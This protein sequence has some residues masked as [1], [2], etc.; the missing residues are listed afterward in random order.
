MKLSFIGIG[1]AFSDDINN[2]AY[3]KKGENMLLIDCGETVFS[4]IKRNGLVE[5]VNNLFVFI[6]HT[7]SDHIGSLSSLIHYMH[8][9][10]NKKVH[11][12]Y[13]NNYKIKNDIETLLKINGN[14]NEQY[15]FVMAEDA[16]NYLGLQ[17]ITL[18]EVKHSPNLHSYAIRL[19][20]VNGNG[21]LENIYYTGD[22]CDTQFL[23]VIL[24]D[25]HLNKIYCDVSLYGGVHLAYDDAVEIF[26]GNKDKVCFMHLENGFIKNR[27]KATGFD[28]AKQ[29]VNYTY[30]K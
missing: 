23:K 27:L 30:E 26:K 10:K 9:V 5:D 25:K 11:L 6:T 21:E 7:H 20:K 15:D 12:V 18:F 17:D 8:Y 28:Y 2:S 24:K 16:K 29:G 19:G 13:G 3:I 22:C 4:E 1:S 14:N